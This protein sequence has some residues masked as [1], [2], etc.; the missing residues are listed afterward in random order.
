MNPYD[1]D[2]SGLEDEG[3][4]TDTGVLL[5]Y[6]SEEVI[7][8]N[9]SHLGGWPVCISNDSVADLTLTG[10]RHGSMNLPRPRAP[11][12]TAKSATGRC[13]SCSS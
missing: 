5:G 2:S 4:Y 12:P 8:D 9:I 7:D 1:S 6:A 10:C 3:D 13:I 11:L